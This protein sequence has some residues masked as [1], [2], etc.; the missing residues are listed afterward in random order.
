MYNRDELT[1]CTSRFLYK[2]NSK[3]TNDNW[4]TKLYDSSTIQRN[5]KKIGCV[6]SLN[7][8]RKP[9]DLTYA[10]VCNQ[11]NVLSN[12]SILSNIIAL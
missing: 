8:L 4:G 9:V 7:W 10:T 6:H 11:A 5:Y 3:D 2:C 12:P 1:I